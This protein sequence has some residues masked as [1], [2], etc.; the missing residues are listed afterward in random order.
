[1]PVVGPYMQF[2]GPFA[3]TF[4]LPLLTKRGRKHYK[5]AVKNLT[6]W[7]P[8]NGTR[9]VAPV[10]AALDVA[11]AFGLQPDE[12]PVMLVP[13]GRPAPGN[14]PQKPRRPITEILKIA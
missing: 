10:D 3:G 8:V 1:M 9:G 13:I 11:R 5:S 4:L 2:L 7:V 12:V 6:P 14:R